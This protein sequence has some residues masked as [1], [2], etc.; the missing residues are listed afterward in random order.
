M[1]KVF[2]RTAMIIALT[3]TTTGLAFA[4]AVVTTGSDTTT[5]TAVVSAQAR[6]TVPST[7]TFNVTNI[8][9]A[10]TA[11]GVSFLADN[12]VSSSAS[13]AL[14]IS[15]S[16]AS[17]FT[18]PVASP[19]WAVADVSWGAAAFTAGTAV[20]GTLAATDV[21]FATCTAGVATCGTTGS[22]LIFTLA[23]NTAVTR[24]GNH[25]LIMTWKFLSV[26]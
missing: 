6:I 21:L 24:S 19:T 4:Q 3:V 5:L 1:R 14:T 25:T 16:G 17:V 26:G 23:P 20:L 2:V 10:T 12:I 11:A 8:A 13:G 15:L 18:A 22:T 9:A 7:V